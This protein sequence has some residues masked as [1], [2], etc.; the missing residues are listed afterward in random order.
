MMPT[1][2]PQSTSQSQAQQSKTVLVSELKEQLIWACCRYQWMTVDDFLQ[3]LAVVYGK[4]PTRNHVGKVVSSLAGGKDETPGQYMYKFA[5]HKTTSGNATRLFVPGTAS[6][7][8]LR[9]QGEKD[10]YLWN[11]PDIMKRYS[12]SFKYHNL[13]VT[14]L[15]ICAALY[16]RDHPDY[17]LAETLLSYDMLRTPPRFSPSD[18]KTSFTV[19]PDLW[20]HI[21][22]DDGTEYPLWLEVDRGSESRNA[23][24][25]L[26]RA[27]LLYFK[28]GQYQEYFG[29]RHVRLCYAITSSKPPDKD[30]R[31]NAMLKWAEEVLKKEELLAWAPFIRVTTIEYETLYENLPRLFAESV[32]YHPNNEESVMLFSPL[33]TQEPPH[34]QDSNPACL[35]TDHPSTQ[36]ASGHTDAGTMC[37]D[38]PP[39]ESPPGLPV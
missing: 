29:T 23:F 9:Q 24:Q 39:C 37:Q 14:R 15:A 13:T 32:W 35:P 30:S 4:P 2:S 31:L 1:P 34:V 10:R 3:W 26:L 7:E 38:V 6:R 17:Y 8:F 21:I 22:A 5:M 16:F 18:P 19:I 11:N 33:T 27:R 25:R 20:L 12:Y 28:S 36:N